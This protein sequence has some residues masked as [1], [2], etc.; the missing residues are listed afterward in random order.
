MPINEKGEFTLIVGS[1]RF[2]FL[3]TEADLAVLRSCAK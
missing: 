3:F 1:E 2:S